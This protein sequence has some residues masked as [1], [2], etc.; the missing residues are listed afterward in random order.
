MKKPTLPANLISLCAATAILL[1]NLPATVEA[2][3]GF[4][5]PLNH[6]ENFIVAHAWGPERWGKQLLNCSLYVV[7]RCS[8]HLLNS[9]PFS[10]NT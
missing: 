1:H 8:P 7:S 5:E 9:I 2:R 4:H 6:L 3:K 10:S